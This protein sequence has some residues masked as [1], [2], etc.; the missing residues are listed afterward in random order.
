MKPISTNRLSMNRYRPL[1]LDNTRSPKIWLPH[2]VGAFLKTYEDSALVWLNLTRHSNERWNEKPTDL[3]TAPFHI[4]RIIHSSLRSSNTILSAPAWATSLLVLTTLTT[5]PDPIP[6]IYRTKRDHEQT[7]PAIIKAGVPLQCLY[8]TRSCSSEFYK[9]Q[10]ACTQS[11]GAIYVIRK[12]EHAREPYHS[13]TAYFQKTQMGASKL[14]EFSVT[15][16]IIFTRK[17][18]LEDI[19][20]RFVLFQRALYLGANNHQLWS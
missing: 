18:A 17:R 2:A 3:V 20:T 10:A 14:S 7:V 8:P 19:C 6:A 15:F 4:R 5:V 12:P 13:A 11:Y 16:L 9:F 1:P